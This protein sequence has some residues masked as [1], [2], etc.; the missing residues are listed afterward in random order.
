MA[1]IVRL[2]SKAIFKKLSAVSAGVK[3]VRVVVDGAQAA[4]RLS[5]TRTI[6]FLDECHRFNKS[7]QI[8]S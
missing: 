8:G 2:H 1:N 6:L 5:K 7:Q 3:E 4:W